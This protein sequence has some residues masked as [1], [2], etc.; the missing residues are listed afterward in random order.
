MPA[1]SQKQARYF[2]WLEHAPDAAGA[3]EKSGL[4]HQQMHDFATTPDRG[5]PKQASPKADGKMATNTIFQQKES[6]GKKRPDWMERAV[7][8]MADGKKPGQL[9]MKAKRADTRQPY[10][11]SGRQSSKPSLRRRARGS[12]SRALEP[13]TAMMADGKKP[14]SGHWMESAFKNAGKPGHSLHASLH[15]A[16]DK[17]IPAQ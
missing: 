6:T 15:V 16:S 17:K 5:L 8:H 13:Q 4:S 1:T 10:P 11:P 2:R 3:R 9:P 12:T 7:P 14:D